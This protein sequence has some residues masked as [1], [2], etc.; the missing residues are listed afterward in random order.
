MR[1]RKLRR[2]LAAG[3]VLLL[4]AVAL[5]VA[6]PR[7]ERVT[8]ENFG[9]V[10]KGLSEAE[11]RAILGPCHSSGSRPD[12]RYARAWFSAE[13]PPQWFGVLFDP[14]GAVEETFAGR[15]KESSLE[16]RWLRARSRLKGLVGW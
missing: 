3:P 9:R 15:A 14:S 6:W 8:R 1:G 7:P 12:G 5:F 13:D 2:A 10:R 4:A 16:V 11:V